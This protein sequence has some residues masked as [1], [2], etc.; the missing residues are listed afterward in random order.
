MGET[1]SSMLESI[2]NATIFKICYYLERGL[3][4]IIEIL[5]K[6]FEVFAG[7]ERVTYNGAQDYLINIF[8]SNKAVNNIYWGMALIG[9]ALTIGFAIFAVVRKMFD[10]SGKQ[11]Q[12]HGQIIWAGVRSIL[13]I[14]GMTAIMTVVLNTTG[15]LMQSIDDLFEDP[16]HLNDPVEREFTGEE[17]AAM[18]RVLSI[19]GNY[20]V[21]DSENNRYNLNLCFNDIRPDMLYLQ[22][23]GVFNY[24]YNIKDQNGDPVL[25]WQSVLAK[26]AT[27]C[28]LK[29]DVKVDIYNEG[30]ARSIREAMDFITQN[31]NPRALERITRPTF[32]EKEDGHLDRMVFLMG[33][34]HAAKASVYNESPAFDDALRGPYYYGDNKSIYDFDQVESDFNIGFA[35]DYLVVWI[36]AIGII[37]NLVVIIMNCV[38]R[39]FNMLFL[40]LIAPPVIAA[41]P[42]DGG[43]KTKQW[44]T[45]FLVQSLSV[46]GTVIAMR[47]LLLFIPIV[48]D[49][50]LVLF[51]NQPVLNA[52]AKY[53]LVFGGFEAAKKSSSILTGILADS[54]GWQAIQAGDM[55]G[56]AMKSIGAVTAT[57]RA[58]LG[59]GASVGGTVLGAATRPVT[60]LA[61]RPFSAIAKHWNAIGTGKASTEKGQ[62]REQVE[63]EKKLDAARREAGVGQ[64][65]GQSNPQPVNRHNNP[66][67]QPPAN[68]RNQRNQHNQPNNQ[69]NNQPDQP[70]NRQNHPVN[71][72]N[73]QNQPVNQQQQNRPERQP[74][75]PHLENLFGPDPQPANQQNQPMNQQ[76]QQNQPVN[77]QQQ[78]NRPERQPVPPHLQ[79]LFGPDPQPGNQQNRPMNQQ[80]QPMNQQNQPGPAQ[81]QPVRQPVPQNLE[82]LFGPD[83]QPANQQNQPVNHAQRPPVIPPRNNGPRNNN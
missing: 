29:Q 51:E 35:T 45:A 13:I 52:I 5:Y 56:S 79:N 73:Q 39:I 31:A 69:P 24:N 12:S 67:P 83:P 19:I 22:N 55:T 36:A 80:N 8:F 16:Y 17:Y 74:V 41:Q 48:I 10:S 53:I 75:P 6:M 61:K 71:Q 46:F 58:G 81:N 25:S 68:R 28:D 77:Q 37:F 3:C 50:Q 7:L 82:N 66:Q 43:A 11:Q 38:A 30:V 64:Y 47:L 26:I 70:A 23:Q 4:Y 72:Q 59:L 49:P 21:V 34:M 2:L 54:A 60:N 33:T 27:S 42:L 65:S 63:R 57:A 14:V 18:G 44:M 62:I 40:Y 9:I 76:N 32:Q 20:S 15:V 78:Q 1:L